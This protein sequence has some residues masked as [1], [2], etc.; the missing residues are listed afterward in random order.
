LKRWRGI[1]YL[2]TNHASIFLAIYDTTVNRTYEIEGKK[3]VSQK[4]PIIFRHR[5]SEKSGKVVKPENFIV[6]SPYTGEMLK[7]PFKIE[8]EVL[9]E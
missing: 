3:F 5:V 2:Q 6:Q 9:E 8:Y 4:F 1:Y 7:I